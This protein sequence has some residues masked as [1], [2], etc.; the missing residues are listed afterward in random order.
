MTQTLDP[1]YTW[2]YRVIGY[3]SQGGVVATSR[4]DLNSTE[5][6]HERMLAREGVTIAETIGP[7]RIGTKR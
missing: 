7:L 5:D 6:A 4:C 3:N 2:M 1:Q